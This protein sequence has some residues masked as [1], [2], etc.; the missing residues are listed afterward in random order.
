MGRILFAMN[1][2]QRLVSG[3]ISSLLLA[4]GLVRAADRLD[5]MNNSLHTSIGNDTLGVAGPCTDPCQIAIE[6]T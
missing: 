2:I 6:L 3:A 5:P 1:S 4:I